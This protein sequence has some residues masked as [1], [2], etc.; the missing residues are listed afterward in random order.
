MPRV[1]LQVLGRQRARDGSR[2][3]RRSRSFRPGRRR[4]GFTLI[5]A[6]IA[7]VIIG[8]AF[9]AMLQLIAK[10][11]EANG[12][13]TELTTAINLA[14]NIHEASIRVA[15]DDIFTLRGTHNPPVNARLQ[16]I[17]GMNGWQ[18]VVGVN[19]VDEN[20][21]TQSVPDTQYE[22]TA[23]VTVSILRNGSEVY[24]SSWLSAASQ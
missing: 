16:N 24:R 19:Y 18:Q 13:G 17:S 8:V 3:P 22:P 9:T 15:Y 1:D 12:E 2:G 11:T 14:G 7:T 23:R 6:A 5:E 20:N 4:S 21:I 10:G